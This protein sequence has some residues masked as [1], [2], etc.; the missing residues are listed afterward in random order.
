M[1]ARTMSSWSSELMSPDATKAPTNSLITPSLVL[2]DNWAR[3]A[4]GETNTEN[5][6][7]KEILDDL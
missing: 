5:F 3:I 7:D 2:E 1:I 6:M 4:L